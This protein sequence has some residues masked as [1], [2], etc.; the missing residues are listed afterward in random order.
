MAG[1]CHQ[2]VE[3]IKQNPLVSEVLRAT[4]TLGHEGHARD[5]VAL[6]IFQSQI[7]YT[8]GVAS[9]AR[10]TACYPHEPTTSAVIETTRI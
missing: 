3:K 4:A 5:G 6:P 7:W 1:L 9:T 10:R 2:Q 8:N